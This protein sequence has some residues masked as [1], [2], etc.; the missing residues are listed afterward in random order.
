[1]NFRPTAAHKDLLALL[2]I[3]LFTTAIRWNVLLD[4][5]L[6]ARGDTLT[7]F[8]PHKAFAARTVRAGEIP[9]WDPHIVAGQP[10]LAD[11]QTA[12][13]SPFTF[14]FYFLPL[15]IA[16]VA[17]ILLKHLL[18]GAF[19]YGFLR[20]LGANRP[21]A[22][23]GAFAY[24]FS[25]T[26]YRQIPWQEVASAT[27][28]MP[29]LFWLCEL[30]IR[31][32]RRPGIAVLA[33]VAFALENVA[34]HPQVTYYV[35]LALALYC[36]IRLAARAIQRKSPRPVFASGSV[37][38]GCVLLGAGLSMIQVLPFKE[39]MDATRYGETFSIRE[40]ADPSSHVSE[41]PR[42][43]LGGIY[44][45]Y[46]DHSNTSYI[47]ILPLL[48]VPAGLLAGGVSGAALAVAGA[49]ALLVALGLEG[50][51]FEPLYRALPGFR[52][53]H[54][55][56]RFLPVAT[57][58]VASLAALGASRILDRLSPS[59]PS[60]RRRALGFVSVLLVLLTG[61]WIA[62]IGTGRTSTTAF[63]VRNLLAFGLPALT[64]LALFAAGAIRRRGFIALAFPLLFL[65][66]AHFDHVRYPDVYGDPAIFLEPPATVRFLRSR[67]GLF[68]AVHFTN[69][70]TVQKRVKIDEKFLEQQVETIYPN[71][72]L[73]MGTYD[74]Q[75]VYSL[76]VE[77][78]T[79][80]VR[81]LNGP[82]R[83][84]RWIKDRLTLLGNPFSPLFDLLDVRYLL[85]V[86]TNPLP[87]SAP[88]V[89]SE[90]AYRLD[91]STRGATGLL[92][93]LDLPEG[94]TP[95]RGVRVSGVDDAG[96]AFAAEGHPV[97]METPEFS[98]FFAYRSD[99]P[100]IECLP[101]ATLTGSPE[102]GGSERWSV[103]PGREATVRFEGDRTIVDGDGDPSL[104]SLPIDART[105][106]VVSFEATP[107]AR[108]DSG[109]YCT[110][111]DARSE[112]PLYT[113]IVADEGYSAVERKDRGVA[114]SRRIH[115]QAGVPLRIE[116]SWQGTRT[117]VRVDGRPLV[118]FR[119]VAPLD[120]A[121]IRVAL[122]ARG[123]PVALRDVRVD[124]AAPGHRRE[125]VRVPVA[126]PAPCVPRT[127][128]VEAAQDEE[129]APPTWRVSRVLLLDEARFARVFEEGEVRIFENREAGPRAFL[130]R[131]YR[132]FDSDATLLAA[133]GRPDF[134]PRSEVLLRE[135]PG[136]AAP[137]G[138][139]PTADDEVEVVAY[140]P[141]RVQLRA[142][143][144]E[145]SILV[146]A[147]SNFPGWE[148][149][150]NGA[151]APILD[152]YHVLRAV[153]VPAGS[154]E[155]EFVYRPPAF[156]L[157]ASASGASA[158]LGLAIAF[159]AF[160]RARS[161]RRGLGR[162]H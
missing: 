44:P 152:A 39:F 160:V 97:T 5:E 76:K 128:R 158:L 31:D 90:G 21:G 123:G 15:D 161:R 142:D 17:Y 101:V 79:D 157:G 105:R 82:E 113:A 22:L 72:A 86:E 8:I 14:P 132:V 49:F 162:S 34:G 117:L 83:G 58:A 77:R 155:I 130:A 27:V 110:L 144:P 96:R 108:D 1:M 136:L 45:G 138:P 61:A 38:L 148:A 59:T 55:P 81:E 2:A 147:D 56:V 114:A 30:L 104:I 37:L 85:T 102:S 16:F 89:E 42:I 25:S 92:I 74:A 137:E 62:A 145:E 28:W 19:T 53:L 47:G 93:D 135:P 11:P 3:L 103:P 20:C 107:L 118:E 133:L 78:F 26:M 139:R 9:L 131:G 87:E 73:L 106:V 153:R 109:V 33:G 24:T 69:G 10:F 94:A 116:F 120:A 100:P 115:S 66:L 36:A 159:I 48:L 18:A 63:P 141:N 70:F 91:A 67:P 23:L 121:Q 125:T 151:P 43:F 35:Y 57:F 60:A 54:G 13:F 46:E 119:D 40:A 134:D 51:L 95:P 122:G 149:R 41:I 71:L 112:A 65:D 84:G 140:R 126:L 32:P 68:R 127:L 52:N 124:A 7:G 98:A 75:G 64:L 6:P 143:A 111:R 154:S 88:L 99:G 12:L 4:G 150:V 50:P 129:S 29:L 146:L 156:R 80:F